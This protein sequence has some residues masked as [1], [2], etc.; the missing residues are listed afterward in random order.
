MANTH[1]QTFS[2]YSKDDLDLAIESLREEAEVDFDDCGYG[3]IDSEKLVLYFHNKYGWDIT[4]LP[5]VKKVVSNFVYEKS[6]DYGGSTT[7]LTVIDG[8]EEW[9][10]EYYFDTFHTL[11]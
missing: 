1:F 5:A 3:S 10:T 4:L 8:Q 11:H 2:F 9:K 6:T 7:R